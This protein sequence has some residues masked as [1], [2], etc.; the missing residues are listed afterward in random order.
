M[1]LDCVTE[2]P[3]SQTDRSQGRM[4]KIT[5]RTEKGEE[6]N[7]EQT[8]YGNWTNED[9]AVVCV[10]AVSW[11][12]FGGLPENLASSAWADRRRRP[13]VQARA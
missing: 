12:G 2:M 3:P 6:G 8:P 10:T 4:A 11:R 13:I 1:P 9:Y 5:G 7:K